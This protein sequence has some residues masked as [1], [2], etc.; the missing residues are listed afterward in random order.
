VYRSYTVG[1]LISKTLLQVDLC[2]FWVFSMVGMVFTKSF[3]W[4]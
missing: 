4:Y 1:R 3:H 2:W